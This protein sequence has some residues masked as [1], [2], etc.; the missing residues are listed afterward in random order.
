MR[1]AT[2]HT[3]TRVTRVRVARHALQQLGEPGTRPRSVIIYGAGLLG[4]YGCAL[5]KQD[6]FNVGPHLTLT[7]HETDLNTSNYLFT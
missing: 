6:N 3:D 4:L 1:H 5:F 7:W 2:S